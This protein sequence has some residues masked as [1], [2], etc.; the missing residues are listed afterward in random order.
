MSDERF[1]RR[2]WWW[3]GEYR[4]GCVSSLVRLKREVLDYCGK[5]GDDIRHYYREPPPN[6]RTGVICLPCLSELSPVGKALV[7]VQFVGGGETVVLVPE[8][9]IIHDKYDFE[10]QPQEGGDPNEPARQQRTGTTADA[11][12]PPGQVDGGPDLQ[13]YLEWR[14]SLKDGEPCGRHRGCL[15]HI[16]HPCEACG[17]I[18]G[19]K[20]A[21]PA[22][23]EG[24]ERDADEV[25]YQECM[26]L[27]RYLHGTLAG[28]FALPHIERTKLE[29]WVD[30]LETVN[31]RVMDQAA[32]I[33][34]MEK[35][36]DT[37]RKCIKV[38]ADE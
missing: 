8:E 10:S 22:Q 1:P 20:A 33:K 38:G 21:A 12:T 36:V 9:I 35:E 2:N 23:L 14:E 32:Q 15:N 16:S 18:G 25:A 4:C 17:R 37:L 19:K 11:T 7:R 31:L 27:F 34:A 6:E 26:E 5:H 13:A 24:E 3:Y 29:V 30:A 28:G